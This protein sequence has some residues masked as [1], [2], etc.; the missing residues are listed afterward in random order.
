MTTED[1][2]KKLS[3]YEALVASLRESELKYRHFFEKS[4][5]MIFV[6]D[7]RGVFININ[8]AGVDMLGYSR[9]DEVLDKGFDDFFTVAGNSLRS[10]RA[11]LEETGGKKAGR[12]RNPL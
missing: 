10:Y 3:E 1:L 2:K 5:A 9:A 8:Q 6:I 12:V 11:A 4:P 7:R